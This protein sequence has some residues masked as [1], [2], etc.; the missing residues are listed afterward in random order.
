MQ[1]SI[2][3]GRGLDLITSRMAAGRENADTLVRTQRR[4]ARDRSSDSQ[5]GCGLAE[6]VIE[7]SLRREVHD[8]ALRQPTG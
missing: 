2:R 7:H 6:L 1:T 4:A 5:L 3:L 8:G